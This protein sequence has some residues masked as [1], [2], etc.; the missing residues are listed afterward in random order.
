M[1]SKK[2]LTKKYLVLLS[3]VSLF[4][5]FLRIFWI[6][7]APPSLNWDEVAHGY[8]AYS[9][10]LTG[11][12]EFGNALPLS[13]RSFD[14]YKPA[15]YAY[16]TI[17][18]IKIFGLTELAVRSVSIISG[19]ITL[20]SS[21]LI[22]LAIFKNKKASVFTAMLIAIS[23]WSLLFSRAAYESNLGLALILLGLT[24]YFY[25]PKKL[26]LAISLALIALSAHSYV[27][28]KLI[29]PIIAIPILL[30]EPNL[31]SRKVNLIKL[32]PAVIIGIPVLYIHLT[33]EATLG[34]FAT[35][36]LF[37]QNV[38]ADKLLTDVASRYFAY[39]SPVNLFHRGSPEPTQQI[40][41]Y[42]MFY[43]FEFILA[44]F[45]IKK[46]LQTK[47]TKTLKLFLV[48]LFT[49]LLPASI[50][51]NWFYPARVLVYFSFLSV[52]SG[53][54]ASQLFSAKLRFTLLPITLVLILINLS[55]FL[56]TYFMYYPKI[57]Q[58]S[59]QYGMKQVLKVVDKYD[60]NY[61]KVVF[62][63]RTAQP[64]I[65]TLFYTRFNPVKYHDFINQTGG[66][67]TPRKNFDFDKYVFRD[68]YWPDDQF[69][70]DTLFV[71]PPSSLP[72]IKVKENKNLDYFEIVYDK[73]GSVLGHI[74]GIKAIPHLH[75]K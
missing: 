38:P 49:S 73:D 11:K 17:P 26:N 35:T 4:A 46:I 42:G 1:D 43:P 65:F 69:L 67:P 16:L 32:L 9:L 75:T 40:P 50:T 3:G 28:Y 18:F 23:P 20:G 41:G 7:K 53:L 13:L 64:H 6:D 57:E 48:I 66:I 33:N 8:N 15:L 12:D 44:I 14:D 54:G 25:L 55:S 39:F 36:T 70:T 63:T 58:G 19:V 62:E 59:W 52:I 5:L 21:A 10:M 68:V 61:S 29:A 51:W 74:A 24:A 30:N 60:D 45:G 22:S 72:E 31:L 71:S 34:R 2:L 56:T 47:K 37:H 27:A